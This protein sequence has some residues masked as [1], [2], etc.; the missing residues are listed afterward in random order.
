MDKRTTTIIRQTNH[1]VDGDVVFGNMAD[2]TGIHAR[3][4]KNRNHDR[5]GRTAMQSK[6]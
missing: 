3:Q 4:K 1:V 5:E 6:R 2:A